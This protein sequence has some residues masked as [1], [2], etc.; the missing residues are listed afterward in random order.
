MLV[1]GV[2]PEQF[3]WMVRHRH[4]PN[5]GLGTWMLQY[6]MHEEMASIP[7]RLRW[8][9]WRELPQL[10]GFVAPHSQR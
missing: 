5:R 7:V 1:A 8:Q 10:F 2:M 9:L 4:V 3:A 6:S